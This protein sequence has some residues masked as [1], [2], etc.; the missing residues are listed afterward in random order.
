MPFDPE[1]PLL[2]IYPKEP[3]TLIWKDI[4]TPVFTAALFTIA[5]TWKQPK[6]PSVAEWINQLWDIYVMEYYSAVKRKENFTICNSIDGPW[7]HYAK[8]N[9]PVRERQKKIWLHSYVES[10]EQTTITENRDRLIDR[11]GWQL[12][13]GR[14]GDAGIEEK[15]LMNMD[16]SVV[17]AGSKGVWGV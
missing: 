2:R 6:C 11:A 10:N 7:E 3:K 15:G 17:I 13:A 12:R 4:S 16:N 8:W 1:I 14:L 9:K 5:K